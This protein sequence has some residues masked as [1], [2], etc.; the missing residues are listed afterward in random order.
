[1][2]GWKQP[3]I[4]VGEQQKELRTDSEP[5]TMKDELKVVTAAGA[6]ALIAE[7]IASRTTNLRGT[8]ALFVPALSAGSGREA[9]SEATFTSVTLK[10]AT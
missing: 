2:A 8:A 6:E 10:P 9:E 1:M 7:E 4:I 3:L 5:K